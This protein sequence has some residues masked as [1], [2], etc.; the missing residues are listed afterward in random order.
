[1]AVDQEDKN[2][3]TP[4]HLPPAFPIE[5]DD[6]IL[7]WQPRP[8]EPRTHLRRISVRDLLAQILCRTTEA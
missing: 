2:G 6:Q 4:D 5:L 1:M 3:K 7:I 8:D